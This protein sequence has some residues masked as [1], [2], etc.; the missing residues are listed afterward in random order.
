MLHEMLFIQEKYS[1]N[2]VL[3][4]RNL[5]VI[6]YFTMSLTQNFLSEFIFFRL[7][8]ILEGS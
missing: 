1:Q 5:Y 2:K 4:P 6:Q 8:D 3:V 7:I